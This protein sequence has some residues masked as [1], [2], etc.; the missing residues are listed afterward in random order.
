M[1]IFFNHAFLGCGCKTNCG[2]GRCKCRKIRQICSDE[3]RCSLQLC[4]NRENSDDK[5][6]LSDVSNNTTAGTM[7]LLNDTYQIPLDEEPKFRK[8]T[9]PSINVEEFDE[10]SSP[11][12]RHR[13]SLFKSPFG[14]ESPGDMTPSYK[15]QNTMFKSPIREEF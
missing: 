13:E 11:K 15:R 2:T 7:S 9:P 3:C 10:S 6:V 5:S 14:K 12:K 4:K 1:T 8:I